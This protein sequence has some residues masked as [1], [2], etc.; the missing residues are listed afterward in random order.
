VTVL[1]SLLAWESGT[2][3]PR[4]RSVEERAILPN[5]KCIDQ[6]PK[7]HLGIYQAIRPPDKSPL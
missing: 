7:T 2:D 6:K 4:A 5:I 1:S 3:V